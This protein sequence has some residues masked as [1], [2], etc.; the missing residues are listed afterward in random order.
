VA[1]LESGYVVEAKALEPYLAVIP[2]DA[3]VP[4]FSMIGELENERARR[5]LIE[6]ISER[7]R[8]NPDPFIPFLNDSR[9][10][11]V[12]SAL[13]I[14]GGTQSPQLLGPLKGLLRHR[15]VRV[16]REALTAVSQVGGG[17]AGDV[18]VEALV[19]PDKRIRIAA[20]RSLA[21]VGRFAIPILV[22]VIQHKDFDQ[23][24]LTEKRAFYE[25]LGYAGGKTV[26]P[27]M[28]DALTRK[29]LFKRQQ[30]DEIRACACEALGWIGGQEARALLEK[31]LKEKS[32]LVRTAAQS[33]IRRLDTGTDRQEFLKEAA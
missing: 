9:P 15:D 11:M 26:F 29:S 10:D 33:A 13:R 12:L 32:P 5:M 20:A 2:E 30:S 7:A 28:E 16:R 19:D 14:L 22:G 31:H 25:A 27:L 18:L 23:R 8:A 4:L 1:S 21:L 24:D 3:L 17:R 6:A